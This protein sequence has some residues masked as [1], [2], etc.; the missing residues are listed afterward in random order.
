MLFRWASL[1]D[2]PPMGLPCVSDLEAE[3][4]SRAGAH[5]LYPESVLMWR[6]VD[7]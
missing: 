1:S 6:G 3:G 4:W 5:P 7:A 2:H